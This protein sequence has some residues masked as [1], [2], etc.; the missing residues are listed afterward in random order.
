M[1]RCSKV[2]HSLIA[3]IQLSRLHLWPLKKISSLNRDLWQLMITFPVM[4]FLIHQIPNTITCSLCL[5]KWYI[6]SREPHEGLL[7]RA[8]WLGSIV[9]LIG[10]VRCRL[11]GTAHFLV[12]WCNW[13]WDFWQDFSVAI[14][15]ENLE[16]LWWWG[17]I[18]I[19]QILNVFPLKKKKSQYNYCHLFKRTGIN[20]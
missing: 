18:F 14:A 12:F 20:L 16:T 19:Y 10:Y 6:C 4:I 1:K 15:P 7:W 8:A 3:F 2:N 5:C 17:T 11:E 9:C 13:E